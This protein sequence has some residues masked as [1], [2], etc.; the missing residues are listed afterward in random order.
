MAVIE[1]QYAEA[2]YELVKEHPQSCHEYLANLK[3]VL[4]SRG[5]Q[6]LLLK[7][8]SAYKRL[9]EQAERSKRYETI[10]PEAART[11]ELVELYRGLTK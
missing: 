2:L 1:A 11:R 3:K 6:K 9:T 7:V 4:D 10:T 8:F 5:H